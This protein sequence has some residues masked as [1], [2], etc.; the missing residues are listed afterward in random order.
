M[1][2]RSTI[3]TIFNQVAQEQQRTLVPISDDVKLLESGLDSLSFA[4]IVAKLEDETGFDPF[5]SGE[6]IEFPI[7]FADFVRLYE[8]HP[9]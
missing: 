5:N 4:I 2:V 7:T 8:S 1:S 3:T 9:R 6:M